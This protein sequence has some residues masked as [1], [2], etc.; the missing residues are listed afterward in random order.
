VQQTEA[1]KKAR[2]VRR[3]IVDVREETRTRVAEQEICQMRR[4]R[5]IL[6]SGGSGAAEKDVGGCRRSPL[7]S[8]ES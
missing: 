8:S 1:R 2:R 6:S 4:R 5:V 7:L 3:G